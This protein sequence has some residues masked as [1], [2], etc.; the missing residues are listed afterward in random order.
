[1][2]VFISGE[3]VLI[4]PPNFFIK[5]STLS[6]LF[7]FRPDSGLTS[8]SALGGAFS[9]WSGLVKG[10]GAGELP[11]VSGA[12]FSNLFIRF[13][14]REGFEVVPGLF[15]EA[16]VSFLPGGSSLDGSFMVDFT[17]LLLL[18]GNLLG[19]GFGSLAADE[20]GR[21]GGAET[22]NKESQEEAKKSIPILSMQDYNL[23]PLRTPQDK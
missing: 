7:I 19:G 8:T 10:G 5:S 15:T 11:L 17:T 9:L 21:G 3:G 13:D 4:L 14:I 22:S 1:M 23:F 20:G 18:P 6:F 16:L 2:S 12:L